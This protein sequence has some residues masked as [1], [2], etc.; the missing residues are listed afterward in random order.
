MTPSRSS[1]QKVIEIKV[2][3]GALV[4]QTI[5]KHAGPDAMLEVED[6][7]MNIHNTEAGSQPAHKSHQYTSLPN[8]L[9]GDIMLAILKLAKV[10]K[11]ALGEWA[12]ATNHGFFITHSQF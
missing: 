12:K 3:I 5:H 9:L 1:T 10:G 6:M 8:S 11:F 7:K 4:F 2:E